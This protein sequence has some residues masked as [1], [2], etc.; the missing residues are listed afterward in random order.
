ME[1]HVKG[2]NLHYAPLPTQTC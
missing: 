2:E 1:D